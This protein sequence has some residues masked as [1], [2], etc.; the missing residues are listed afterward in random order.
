V[1]PPNRTVKNTHSNTDTKIPNTEV[2]FGWYLPIGQGAGQQSNKIGSKK[3]SSFCNGGGDRDEV[4]NGDHDDSGI[5]DGDGDNGGMIIVNGL[6]KNIYN[7]QYYP[8]MGEEER[9]SSH[10]TAA[11][12]D[13]KDGN[14]R[15]GSPPWE[16]EEDHR[17]R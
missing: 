13:D 10:A 8:T 14:A 6:V 4:D 15:G 11:A 7:N 17:F 9:L 1:F 12:N 16:E 5:D 3:N 2:S